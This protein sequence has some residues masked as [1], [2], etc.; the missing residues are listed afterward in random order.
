VL[1]PLNKQGRTTPAIRRNIE[2]SGD[3]VSVLAQR[4]NVT[5][6][7]I[8]KWRSR[9]SFQDFWNI[10]YTLET[11][12]TPARE[13]IVLNLGRTLLHPLDD[14]LAVASN[15]HNGDAALSGLSQFLRPRTM[16]YLAT[17]KPK[18]PAPVHNSY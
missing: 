11:T 13:S 4:Y 7:A 1:I 12:K 18:G 2:T 17:P 16:G 5:S 14:L 3:S 15:L 6:A 8:Y 9:E 10:P